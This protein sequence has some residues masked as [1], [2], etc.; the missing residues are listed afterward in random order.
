[1]HVTRNNPAA[2]EVDAIDNAIGRFDLST[3][4]EVFG[5]MLVGRNGDKLW[6]ILDMVK[7]LQHRG[8]EC[9]EPLFASF[10]VPSVP[11]CFYFSSYS[12]GRGAADVGPDRF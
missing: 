9:T 12:H 6:R 1:M 7:P 2:F 3:R 8:T 11:L 5:G 10:S 4:A